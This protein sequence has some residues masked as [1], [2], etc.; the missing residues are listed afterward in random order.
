MELLKRVADK[1]IGEK[2]ELPDLV[3]DFF[4]DMDGKGAY[5]KEHYIRMADQYKT[6]DMRYDAFDWQNGVGWF[7]LLEANKKLRDERDW[8]FIRAWTDAHLERGLPPQSINSTAP[9]F[10]VLQLCR[11]TGDHR[12]RAVCE[13]A[14]QYCMAQAARADQGTLEHSVNSDRSKLAS[15]IWADTAFMAGIFLAEWGRFTGNDM[16]CMEALRQ[17]RLHY[18]DLTDPKTGLMYHAYNCQLRHHMSG[19]RWGRANGWGVVSSVEI[20][21]RVPDYAEGRAQVMEN[22]QRHADALKQYQDASGSWHTVLD[23]PETYL[24][25]TVA[26]AVYYG[27]KKALAAGYIHGDYRDMLSRAEQYIKAHAAPDGEALGTSAGTP[28]MAS[29]EEYGRIPCAMSYYGQ[30]LMLMALSQMEE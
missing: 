6:I 4:G 27:V 2:Y 29:V 24:E 21:Q 13:Y 19:V 7:G 18:H 20:L 15:Q 1:T 30:G 9:M 8:D 3:F 12:Y 5:V 16:Y 28:V 10:A 22:L 11:H 23:H 17:I 14:A 26:C 25:T